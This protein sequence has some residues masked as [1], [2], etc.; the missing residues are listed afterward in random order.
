MRH[1]MA[2]GCNKNNGPMRVDRPQA[3]AQSYVPPQPQQPRPIPQI[4]VQI[5]E[6]SKGVHNYRIKK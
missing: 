5:L 3:K 2:C 6:P 1:A 4:Q